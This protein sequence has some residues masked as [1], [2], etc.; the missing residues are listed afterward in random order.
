MKTICGLDCETCDLRASCDGCTETGGHPF[1][2]SCMIALC[3]ETKGCKNR[4]HAFSA[5]CKL[6]E[7]LI[8]EFNA[9][10]IA[11]MEPV[12][13]LNALWGHDINL[14]YTLPGGQSIRFW[15]DDRIYLGNQL[16]KNNSDRYYG[17]TADEQFLLVCEYAQGGTDAEIVIYR[18]RKAPI[19][20]SRCGLHCTGCSYKDATGCSGCIATN[21]HPFHGECPIALCC[22][23]KGIVHCGE[24]PDMPCDLLNAYSC[25]PEHGDTPEGARIEQCRQ[26]AAAKPG[27]QK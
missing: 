5:P 13:D 14:T 2:G 17:L 26:W 11:D 6:K 4:G 12:T 20:D 3:C 8:A 22:Q 18:R 16:R 7:T 15:D 25:D 27:K 10:G 9:L 24:C 23:E 19:A 1:G 21:G